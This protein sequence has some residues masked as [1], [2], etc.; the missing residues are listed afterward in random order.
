MTDKKTLAH[1][2]YEIVGALG[3]GGMAYVFTAYDTRLRVE[4]AIKI[5]APRLFSNRKIRERFES[6]A[7]TMAQLHHKNILTIH[8]IGNEDQMVY[9]VMEML[10]GG[11]LMDRIE[12]H[13]VLHPQLAITAAIEMAE[14]LGFAHQNKV[15]HRDVKPHNVLISRDGILKVADFG[16]ARIEDGLNSQTRTGAVMGTLA[17]MAPEQ[18]LSARKAEARSDLYAVAAS[19]YVMLTDDNPFELYDTEVQEEKL[20]SLIPEVASFIRKGC[21]FDPTMR[22]QDAGEMIAELKALR[23]FVPELPEEALP[24][25]IQS[26]RKPSLQQK[27]E[28]LQPMWHTMMSE[29][30]GDSSYAY[31]ANTGADVSGSDASDTVDFDLFSSEYDSEGTDENHEIAAAKTIGLDF[32]ESLSAQNT[33]IPQES[34]SSQKELQE[35]PPKKESSRIDSNESKSNTTL[36]MAMFAIFALLLGAMLLMPESKEKVTSSNSK[37]ANVVEEV[38]EKKSNPEVIDKSP[39]QVET[40]T[41]ATL[42]PKEETIVQPKPKPVQSTSQVQATK[43]KP[44]PSTKTKKTD[45]GFV[46]ITALP[47]RGLTIKINGMTSAKPMRKKKIPVGTHRYT[48]VHKGKTKKGKVEVIKGETTRICW[49]FKKDSKCRVP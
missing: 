23:E 7:A 9:M 45:F 46:T 11:S 18:K 22:H 5:L 39:E 36:F 48:I 32:D 6:E 34:S 26:E 19:L 12:N 29:I 24:L 20:G 17:Y 35:V 47:M 4:R 13:G 27:K 49:N 2:R 31:T 3:E 43:A 1:G 40:K 10:L 14:G 44:K 33:I 42:P 37:P 25:Y 28:G 8:D 15:I 16:I 30:T 38:K 41:E 21:H